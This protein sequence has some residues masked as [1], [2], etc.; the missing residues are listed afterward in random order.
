MHE[1]F[2]AKP[3]PLSAEMRAAL[4]GL[5]DPETGHIRL[6]D[7]VRCV[8]YDPHVGYY[9][10]ARQRVG[11]EHAADFY[12][13][14]S[15]GTVFRELMLEAV[16]SGLPDAPENYTFVELGPESHGG[17]IGTGS[18]HP[19]K[20]VR[21]IRPNEPLEIPDKAVVFSNELFDAQPFQ[22]FVWNGHAWQEAAV[23]LSEAG[24]SWTF[25]APSDLP[26]CFPAD[27]PAPSLIDWPSGAHELMERICESR[28][29]GLFVACDYGLDRQVVLRERPAGTART[30]RQHQTGADLLRAPGE[31]D[32]THHIIWDELESRMARHGFHDIALRRQESFFVHR[33]PQTIARILANS[34][35]EFSRHKQTL[36]ELLHPHHMGAKFQVLSARRG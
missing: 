30:Y 3:E 32:I 7:F 31:C 28:W 12:T 20:E 2:S 19:F 34:A 4:E 16:V 6:P 35:Q 22:R 15:L 14:A 10:R 8:L 33:A 36:M 23:R 9:C 11:R 1:L 21:L 5:A 29:S 26:E 27:L 18:P 13:A 25:I 17:I 24:V